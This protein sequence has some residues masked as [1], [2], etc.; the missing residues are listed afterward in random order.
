[1]LSDTYLLIAVIAVAGLIVATAPGVSDTLTLFRPLLDSNTLGAGLVTTFVSALL[2][3]LFLV[4]AIVAVRRTFFRTKWNACIM[5]TPK[6]TH[7]GAA[8]Q[9]Q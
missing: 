7:P 1:M 8:V 5:L 2:A 9:S 4:L 6:Q 3:T